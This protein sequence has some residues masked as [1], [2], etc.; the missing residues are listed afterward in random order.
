V[1]ELKSSLLTWF[2]NPVHT[3]SQQKF[4]KVSRIDKKAFE[5]T[6]RTIYF[7]IMV[8]FVFIF[9][10]NEKHIYT[11]H[12]EIEQILRGT[13]DKICPMLLKIIAPRIII[14]H[15]AVAH[16]IFINENHFVLEKK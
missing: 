7:V 6:V 1:V 2:I 12:F 8:M 4:L 14:M 5:N 16:A 9:D 15:K 13:E 3:V 11:T 10:V